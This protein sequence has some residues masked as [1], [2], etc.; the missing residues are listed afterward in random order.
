MFLF[1]QFNLQE[2]LEA[3]GTGYT[4]TKKKTHDELKQGQSVSQHIYNR[5]EPRRKS[6]KTAQNYSSV[7]KDKML[8]VRDNDSE[9]GTDPLQ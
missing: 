3:G 4:A 8:T 9:R 2:F 1:A 7:Q 5:N 6:V